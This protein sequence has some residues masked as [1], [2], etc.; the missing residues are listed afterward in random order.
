M[1]L[2]TAGTQ[3]VPLRLSFLWKPPPPWVRDSLLSCPS[4]W[5][6]R[7]LRQPRFLPRGTTA[8]APW[9]APWGV[10]WHDQYAGAGL[11]TGGDRRRAFGCWGS[12]SDGDEVHASS[13]VCAFCRVVWPPQGNGWCDKE[14]GEDA[15]VVAT[16]RRLGMGM[17]C[18]SPQQ[19]GWRDCCVYCR[20][21]CWVYS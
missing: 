15:I 12:E 4:R 2:R 7:A 9:L 5:E 18:F 19:R 14:A 8:H 6:G 21:D 3:T 10:S 13:P 11:P 20:R 1:D 16:T 17:G